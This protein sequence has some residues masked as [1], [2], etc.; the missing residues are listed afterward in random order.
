MRGRIAKPTSLKALAGNAG[1]RRDTGSGDEPAPT[2]GAPEP[3]EIITNNKAACK[4]WYEKCAQ[5]A[6][7]PGWLTLMD[8]DV[9]ASYCSAWAL[10]EDAEK[11]FPKAKKRHRRAAD[12]TERGLAWAELCYLTGQRRQAMKDLKNFGTEFG[13][14]AASRTRLRVNP[15]QGEL[16]LGESEPSPFARSLALAHGSSG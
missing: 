4:K 9:L 8:G 16:A 13:W 11:E 2:P 10:F 6:Q 1:H 14:S 5:M 7:V 15:G 3:P 12:A